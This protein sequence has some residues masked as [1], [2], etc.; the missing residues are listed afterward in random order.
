MSERNYTIKFKKSIQNTKSIILKE[1]ESYYGYLNN[2]DD[3]C[4]DYLVPVQGQSGQTLFE[5]NEP[6]P[7]LKETEYEN[8]YI[9]SFHELGFQPKE[10]NDF[11]DHI[12]FEF[13]VKLLKGKVFRYGKEYNQENKIIYLSRYNFNL[14][15]QNES[16]I[17]GINKKYYHY[18]YVTPESSFEDIDDIFNTLLNYKRPR[19]KEYVEEYDLT[20]IKGISIKSQEIKKYSLNYTSK[21]INMY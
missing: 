10:Q 9:D 16:C 18:F 12:P 2:E 3:Y 6:D 17:I 15:T 13:I 20:D 11:F 8:I 21:K 4:F 19:D 1:N 5:V 7:S 14:Y